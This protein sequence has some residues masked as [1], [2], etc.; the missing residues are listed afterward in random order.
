MDWPDYRQVDKLQYATHRLTLLL[1][2]GEIYAVS[3]KTAVYAQRLFINGED[4]GSVGVP[5]A[6]REECVPN[7]RERTYFFSAS[8]ERVEIILH[9]ANFVHGKSGCNPP[10]SI[11]LGSAENVNTLNRR[12][13]FLNALIL[14]AL[15]TS[16]LYH[17]SQFLLNRRPSARCYLSISCIFSRSYRR[18]I[19]CIGNS[20]GYCTKRRYTRIARSR[21][22]TE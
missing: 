20:R 14:N 13:S 21:F 15:L 6:T 2:P 12:A 5:A 16:F 11:A 22:S 17:L 4:M 18:Y 3:M 8:T 9:T 10:D 1:P 19:L 7:T